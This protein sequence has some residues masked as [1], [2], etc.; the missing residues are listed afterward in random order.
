MKGTLNPP[1]IPEKE[2]SALVKQ[3]L[4]LTEPQNINIQQQA[5]QIQLLK[6]EIARLKNHPPGRTLNPAVWENQK[7]THQ[8]HRVVNGPVPRNNPRPLS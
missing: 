2:Q 4:A 6:D 7:S 3:L 8:Y 1:E 5:E